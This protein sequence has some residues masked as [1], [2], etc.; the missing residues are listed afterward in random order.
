VTGAEPLLAIEGLSKRYPGVIA[1]DDVSFAVSAG[2]IHALLGENGAGKSTLVKMIAG[3]IRPDAGTMTLAARPH[4][5]RSPAEARASGVGMVFQ[6][7]SLF[8]ALTVAENIVLGLPS[9]VADA[10][11]KAEISGVARTY[12]LA[13]EPDRRVATLSVG[14]RQRVEIVRCLLQNP[15]LIIMDEPTSVLTPT[16]AVD[17]FITLRRLA[18]EGRAILYISHKLDEVRSLCS[19]ATILRGGRVVGRCDPARESAR[20]LAEMMIGTTLVRPVRGATQAGPVRLAVEGLTLPRSGPFGVA[21]EDISFEVRA[22]EILGIAGVAGNGQGELVQAL[23]GVQPAAHGAIRLDGRGIGGESPAVRRALGLAVVPEERLGTASVPG[24]SLVE[25]TLLAASPRRPLAARGLI[26]WRQAAAFAGE[27]VTAFDV[28]TPGVGA[29]ARSLS[30][31]NLQKYVV[32]R[33]VLQRPEVLIAAQPTWGVDAGAAAAIHATL[34]ELAAGGAA[35]V[36]ISQ[37][38][39][40]L[41]AIATRI[42]VVAGGRLSPA[43]VTEA[44]SIEAIGRRMGGSEIPAAESPHA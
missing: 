43:E 3:V 1:N 35:V 18:G 28:R 7:F 29:A 40:E 44:L 14:E 25:N 23:A 37:D 41:F 22:G 27:V 42:A 8:E 33:A 39:D 26:D 32:G 30:G 31:G 16:E 9:G 13:V 24:M 12:G 4:A 34:L 10:R 15:R 17:L 21:L 36:V 11:L 5:P 20:S 6:H 19:A 2:E 38:L